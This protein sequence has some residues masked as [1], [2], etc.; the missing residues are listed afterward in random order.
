MG[1]LADVSPGDIITSQRQNDITDYIQQATHE[2]NTQFLRIGSTIVI[3]SG[4][5][6]S[7]AGSII[8]T[9]SVKGVTGS[10]TNNVYASNI[11]SDGRDTTFGTASFSDITSGGGSFAY[12]LTGSIITTNMN[13]VGSLVAGYGIQCNGDIVN[14][15]SIITGSLIGS[16][17]SYFGGVDAGFIKTGSVINLTSAG[18]SFYSSTGSLIMFLS[19]TGNLGLLGNQYSL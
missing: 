2:V 17:G 14:V 5:N 8:T 11:I 6:I 9:G 13:V 7:T 3:D 19:D 10:F 15:G 4:S 16:T 1:E 12:I 18:L